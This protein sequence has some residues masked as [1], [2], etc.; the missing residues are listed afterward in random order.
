[1]THLVLIGPPGAPTDAVAEHIAASLG[2]S[3]H[4]T[5]DYSDDD[6]SALGY[7]A[8][9]DVTAWAHGGAYASYRL[10]MP[11]RLRAVRQLLSEHDSGVFPLLPDFTVY[12]DDALREQFAALLADVPHSVA[13]LPTPDTDENARLLD[14]DL[15]GF[16]DWSAVNAYWI[17]NP[18]NERLATHTVYTHG[19]TAEQTRD[20]ILALTNG[21]RE[22]V[23]IGPK[24]TGKTTIGRLLADAL[25]VPQVSLDMLGGDYLPET[26]YDPQ[27]A[28]QI[29][30]DGGIFAWLRYRRPYEAHIVERALA[31]HRDAVID[32]GGGHSVYEDEAHFARVQAALA[33]FKHV[34]LILPS[35]DPEESIRILRERFEAD[36]A[37]ERRVQRLLVTSPVYAQA[38]AHTVYTHDRTPDDIAAEVMSLLR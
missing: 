29:R 28:R 23:L 7:D 11:L 22:I 25:G 32:F 14:A 3:I 30:Q 8:S 31:D 18:S 33:P 17:R 34:V 6:W 35:P 21:S 19:K 1:M 24:L 16:P 5:D 13:L 20:E 10:L 37:S 15:A 2:L 4:S 12:E 36:V 26:D 9:A 38:A 27:A